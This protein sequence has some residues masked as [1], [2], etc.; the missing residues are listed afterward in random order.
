MSLEQSINTLNATMLELIE[1]LKLGRRGSP[2]PAPA[3]SPAPAQPEVAAVTPAAEDA[4]T[5]TSPQAKAV[6]KTPEP[7]TRD[8]PP[9]PAPVNEVNFDELKKAF[10]KLAGT[11]RDKAV[12]I[13]SAHGCAKLT[14]AKP[15]QY[16]SILAAIEAAQ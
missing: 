7:V 5:K 14:E 6:E 11:N 9:A 1:Q 12:E 3:S 8:T 13:L 10:L 16:G 2:S 15:E 4:A